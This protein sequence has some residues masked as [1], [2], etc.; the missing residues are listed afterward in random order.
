MGVAK[1]GGGG[2]YPALFTPDIRI[3]IQTPPFRAAEALIKGLFDTGTHPHKI[4]KTIIQSAVILFLHALA[5][6]ITQ[7]PGVPVVT[8]IYQELP[9]HGGSERTRGA[10]NRIDVSSLPVGFG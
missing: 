4:I 1:G 6:T 3:L 9:S 2:G 10:Q 5:G 7:V 8:Q